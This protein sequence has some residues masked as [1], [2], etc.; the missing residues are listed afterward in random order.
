MHVRKLMLVAAVAA[1]SLTT[2]ATAAAP[3]P[4]LVPKRLYSGFKQGKFG[5]LFVTHSPTSIDAGQNNV[6]GS[7]FPLSSMSVRCRRG[8]GPIGEAFIGMPKI[9]LALKHG[10][11]SF[12]RT[13]RRSRVTLTGTGKTIAPKV[14]LSGAV[15]SPSSIKGRLKV[16]ARGCKFSTPYTATLKPGPVSPRA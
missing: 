2:A 1:L 11:W 15:A 16:A 4:R 6:I 8:S 5:I 10:R 14:S 12:S 3:A 13:Y 9:K 7:Q